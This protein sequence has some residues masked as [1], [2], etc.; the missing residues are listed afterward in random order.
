MSKSDEA[1][2]LM[3]KFFE[4]GILEPDSMVSE[5]Q[6][7][8]LIKLGRTPVREAIQ[9]MALGRMLRIHPNRGLE[10]PAISIEEQLGALEVRRALEVLAVE[11]ACLRATEEQRQ[12]MGALSTRLLEETFSLSNYTI[13]VRQTHQMISDSA[14]N[15]HIGRTMQPLQTLSRR[16]WIM[17]LKSDIDGHIHK[18]AKLHASILKAIADRDGADATAASL[19]LND[20]LVSYAMAALPHRRIT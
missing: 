8:E 18:G 3:T 14:G 1:F 7:V 17:N 4:E 13:T 11:L 5:K 9:R 2:E 19:A 10:V 20:Y 15:S 6:L 16:F 12:N